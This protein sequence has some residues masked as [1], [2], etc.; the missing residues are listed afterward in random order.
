M[1]QSKNGH[2]CL[3]W[4]DAVQLKVM[5]TSDQMI[6]CSV[7]TDDHGMLLFSFIYVANMRE[8]R[9]H[10]CSDLRDLYSSIQSPWCLLG[11]FNDVIK[12]YEVFSLG[13]VVVKDQSMRDLEDLLSALKMMDHPAA[14]PFF[15]RSNKRVEHFQC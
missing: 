14:G 12:P 1:A 3:F 8:D 5:K 2:I 15:T 7:Q 6:H 13:N 11:D 4:K 9:T 10:L